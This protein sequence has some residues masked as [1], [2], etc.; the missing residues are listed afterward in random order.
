MKKKSGIVKVVCSVILGIIAGGTL[1]NYFKNKIIDRGNKTV[2]KFKNYYSLLNQWLSL[3]NEGKSLEKYFIDNGYSTIA[4]YGMGEMGNRLYEELKRSSITV[5][6]A[7]DKNAGSAF[8]ELEVYNLEEDLEEVD[9]V[10]VTAVFAFEEIYEELSGQVDFPII[11][12]ED[13]I[14][15]L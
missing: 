9:V 13:V 3:K 11:S 10:V 5:K 4:I 12:L 14:Y 1:S 7:I 15:E 2:D 6:Y 8:S